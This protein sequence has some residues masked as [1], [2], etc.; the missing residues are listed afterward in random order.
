MASIISAGTTDSTSL[1]ISSDRS[2]ILQL[3]SNNAVT[4]VTIDASQNVGIGTTSPADKLDVTRVSSSNSTGGLSLT[5]SDASGYGSAVSWRLKLD[6]TNISTVS[7]IYA[8][9]ANATATFMPFQTTVGSTL[10]ERMRIDL[11][12]VLLVNTTARA[13]APDHTSIKL[14]VAGEAH[15]QS[16]GSHIWFGDSTNASPLGI[17]EGLVNTFGTDQDFLSVYY[18]STCRFFTGTT[19][20]A[21][22]DSNGTLLVGATVAS[23]G[24]GNNS[25]GITIRTTGAASVFSN[26]ASDYGLVL[27][28]TTYQS[29]STCYQVNFRTLNQNVGGIFTD[30]SSTTYS[31]TSDYRLKESVTPITGALSKVALLNPVNYKWKRDGSDGQGFIAH[32]LAEV[33]PQAV[34]GERDAL[35]AEGNPVYQGIDTSF[36]V[37]TLTA[38]IQELKTIVDAQ[39]AEIAELK[40]KA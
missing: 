16:Q 30:N 8:E 25:T 31:T 38:A 19:E 10:A 3:A 22:F 15:L 32:E 37:A 26:S 29:G 36:L 14:A 4:A 21:R 28:K 20:S 33:C 12:G 9:A 2:G 39:A 27:N 5:N 17:G 11:N 35:D 6:G 13:N 34:I 23:N 18:R 24:Y 1:N 7:R 40:A